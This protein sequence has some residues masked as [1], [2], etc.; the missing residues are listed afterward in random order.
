MAGRVDRSDEQFIDPRLADQHL[1][2]AITDAS[3]YVVSALPSPAGTLYRVFGYARDVRGM[4]IVVFRTPS[5]TSHATLLQVYDVD[6]NDAGTVF[7]VL[8]ALEA[9]EE[10]FYDYG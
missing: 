1:Q 7:S 4:K 3:R 10:E 2:Q 9:T 6:R 8:Y 5:G